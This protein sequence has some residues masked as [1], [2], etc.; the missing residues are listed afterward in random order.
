MQ[1]ALAL[2]DGALGADGAVELVFNLQQRG[3][4]LQ[5]VATRVADAQR[6]VRRPGAGERVLQTGGVAFQ[7][8][9]AD[10]QRGLSVALVAQAAHA[11]RRAV[12][13]VQRAPGQN[14]QFVLA[15]FHKTAAHGGRRAQQHQQ[16]KRMAAEVADEAEILG[17]AHTRHGP[18]VV[19]ARN[20]L[21]APPVAVAQ[22]HA[23]HTFRAPHVGAAVAPQRNG[24]VGGQ[25]TRHAGGPQHLV[26]LGRQG[27]QCEL[28]NAGQLVQAA[29]HAGVHAGDELELALAVIGG[30]VRVR[31]R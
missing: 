27:A 16:Q 29:L 14:L 6:L 9:V 15:P 8:V 25:P 20:G 28:V 7:S 19:N 21:H 26:T 22:A 1:R 30:D 18:V 3:G 13:H 10:T 11:Q 2:L 4:Q 23:V 12:R 31:Q 5:V 17:A 24:F